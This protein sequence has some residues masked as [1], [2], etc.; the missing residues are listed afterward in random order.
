MTKKKLQFT[1]V[2]TTDGTDVYI[3]MTYVSASFL[4]LLHPDATIL[5]LSD[6]KSAEIVRR[7]GHP[8]LSVVDEL[9]ECHATGSVAM[10]LNR[11]IKT[12][13]RLLTDGDVLYLDAD[14]LCLRRVDDLFNYAKHYDVALALDY[15][16]RTRRESEKVADMNN[17]PEID[18]FG[19]SMP[20][21]G[22]FNGGVIFYRD[23]TAA[24]RFSQKWWELW[25]HSARTGKFRDQPALNQALVEA[26]SRVGVLQPKFN[27]MIRQRPEL[28]PRA[29]ILHFFYSIDGSSGTVFDGLVANA[30]AG[31][32]LDA[33][34]IQ[35]VLDDPF[36]WTNRDSI[37][38]NWYY[39]RYGT[40]ARVMLRRVVNGYYN[41]VA[42][43]SSPA[44]ERD[45]SR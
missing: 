25:K 18:T 36:P 26:S 29:S 34:T 42:S 30:A 27:T 39:R 14:T 23:C 11:D 19:W 10:E 37:R 17:W 12:R 1:Y 13:L 21:A 33:S 3:A 40:L 43:R 44:T 28:S 9:R 4:R 16:A 6:A 41:A 24:H 45:C 15:N 32:M 22:Y 7:K 38:R 2:L 31:E 20:N 5:V 35:A 8:L